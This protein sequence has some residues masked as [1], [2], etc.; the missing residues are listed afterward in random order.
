MPF[1]D[2]V[3]VGLVPTRLGSAQNTP[4]T[5]CPTSPISLQLHQ[6][7]RAALT[8]AS[9]SVQAATVTVMGARTLLADV[10]GMCALLSPRLINAQ[11]RMTDTRDR[12]SP[13]AGLAAGARGPVT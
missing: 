1:G 5:T 10:E 4:S 7:A 8:R 11:M 9:S 3:Y 6:E 2:L 13:W 12:A